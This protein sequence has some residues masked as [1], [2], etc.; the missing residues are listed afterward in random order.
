MSSIRSAMNRRASRWKFL[1]IFLSALPSLTPA[2][3][4]GIQMTR[5][6]RHIFVVST[7]V[8]AA[9]VFF[10]VPGYTEE[11]GSSDSDYTAP[12]EFLHPYIEKNVISMDGVY[13]EGKQI[14]FFNV[15]GD[16]DYDHYLYFCT[17]GFSY[18][19]EDRIDLG[20]MRETD[21]VSIKTVVFN[22]V[23]YVFYSPTSSSLNATYY[24]TVTVDHGIMGD[25]WKL[26]FGKEHR[27]D[28]GQ[29]RMP[30]AT[31]M[32]GKLYIIYNTF[33]QFNPY[34]DWY[35]ICSEGY[36][37]DGSLRFGPLTHFFTGSASP[38]YSAG[39]TVFQ[40]PDATD[41]FKEILML[42]YLNPPNV[43]RYFFFDG[44]NPGYS[45]KY[46]ITG[47]NS[48]SVRLYTGTVSGYT[49]DKYAVQVFV[50]HPQ[51]GTNESWASMYHSE[52]IPSGSDGD[53]GTWSPQWSLLDQSN[54]DTIHCT[55]PYQT[56]GHWTIIP[57]FVPSG[58]GGVVWWVVF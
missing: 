24:R 43:F 33:N 45:E 4:G 14:I 58:G 26:M 38:L 44:E 51:N 40:V 42:A 35:Y 27:L 30:L 56:D 16:A 1:A 54:Q 31:V 6:F 17:P 57:F 20:W 37:E 39:G 36:S 48:R 29:T 22:N 28:S 9:L 47:L 23:L 19:G 41:G 3:K 55:E 21:N 46:I 34:N 11:Y 5:Y 50:T 25:E 32:N 10:A 53:E 13:F 49:A 2:P 7:L 8:A 15:K 12:H 18:D 52:Y